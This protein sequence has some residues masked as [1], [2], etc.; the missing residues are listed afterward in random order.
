MNIDKLVTILTDNTY[1]NLK[2]NTEIVDAELIKLNIKQNDRLDLVNKFLKIAKI[3]THKKTRES[4]LRS[5]FRIFQKG[6]EKTD[7][8]GL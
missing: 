7:C 8:E 3:T 6:I 1:Q 5:Y 4:Y 2:K